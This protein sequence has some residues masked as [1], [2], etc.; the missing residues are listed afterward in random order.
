MSPPG[1]HPWGGAGCHRDTEHVRQPWEHACAGVR[2][3]VGRDTPGLVPTPGFG[4]D[5]TPVGGSSLCPS[6]APGYLPPVFWCPNARGTQFVSHAERGSSVRDGLWWA[7]PPWGR[8]A[9][10]GGRRVLPVTAPS[11]CSE[12]RPPR[13]PWSQASPVSLSDSPG[14]L[15]GRVTGRWPRAPA[16]PSGPDPAAL[17]PQWPSTSSCS[18]S[19]TF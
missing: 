3:G 16:Q 5:T 8:S 15:G 18:T 2:V 4:L 11:V 13:A 12:A 19:R 1:G 9:W 10:A 17:S 6:S 7:G 14:G